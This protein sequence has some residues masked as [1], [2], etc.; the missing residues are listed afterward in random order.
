MPCRFGWQDSALTVYPSHPE[1]PP[2]SLSRREQRIA[3]T[4]IAVPI[5]EILASEAVRRG[6]IARHPAEWLS[7]PCT[8][9]LHEHI[10]EEQRSETVKAR[11]WRIAR[12]KAKQALADEATAAKKQKRA[13]W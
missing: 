7:D 2:P 6:M 9:A 13:R 12:H 5:M 4:A 11:A 8:M 10:E 3:T 1:A